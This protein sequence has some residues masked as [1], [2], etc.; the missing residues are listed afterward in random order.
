MRSGIFYLT[1]N[2]IYNF[3]NGI[4]TQT[5]LLLRGL[6]YTKSDLERQFGVLDVHLVCPLPDQATWGY[7]AQFF[8]QQQGRLSALGGH[9]HLVP[10][11]ARREQELWDIASWRTLSAHAAALLLPKLADYDRCLLICIDQPWLQTPL[12]MAKMRPLLDA[13]TL[14]V[15]YNT[16]FIRNWHTPDQAEIAWEQEGLGWAHPQ[17]AVYIAD[18]CPSFTA[19]LKAHFTFPTAA[20]APYTSSILVEDEEF[21]LQNATDIQRVLQAYGIPLHEDIV[22]AFGRAAPIKGF[23]LLIPALA[24]VRERCHF[25][26]ISVPYG[27]DDP[28]Q[29]LYDRLLAEHRIQATHIRHFTRDLPRALCQWP[30]TKMVVIPSQQETF[31][32]IYLEVALWARENGPVVVA[33]QVGGFVDQIQPGTTGFFIDTVSPAAMMHTLQHVLDLPSQMHAAIRCNAYQRVV[34]K[35]D[36]RRNFPQTLHWLWREPETGRLWSPGSPGC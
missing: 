30:R 18:V 19:H 6:E 14:L 17:Y 13:Q 3:T 29:R 7:D 24:A 12:Y 20:L 32:N 33:S 15:L 25:V 26:L 34:Q 35:Y 10:Y 36:F 1:Y 4:G 8:R 22:L 9:L 11:K 23:E 21:A 31:S 16:A 27:N 28:Q 5:Q 2:G